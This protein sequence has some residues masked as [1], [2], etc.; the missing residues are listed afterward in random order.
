MTPEQIYIKQINDTRKFWG[1]PKL[2][3]EQET[4]LL[5]SAKKE[6]KFK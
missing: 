6:G 3:K 4:R 5:A 1:E 2:T